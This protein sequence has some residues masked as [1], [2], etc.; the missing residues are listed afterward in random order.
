MKNSNRNMGIVFFVGFPLAR[1][2]I[3]ES[4]VGLVPFEDFSTSSF[5]FGAPLSSPVRRRIFL[6]PEV[7]RASSCCHLDTVY[8]SWAGTF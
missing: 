2:C 4:G 6:R 8:L 5:W 7:L 3:S 1:Y